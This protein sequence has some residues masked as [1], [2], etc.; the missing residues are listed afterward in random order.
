MATALQNSYMRDI[1][2]TL[3]TWIAENRAFAVATVVGTAGSSPRVIGSTMAV[4]EDGLI[5]GSVS[6]GCVEGAVV[7]AALRAIKTGKGEMLEFGSDSDAV[8]FSVGLS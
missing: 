2:T 8:L 7:Q 4:R 3:S 1:A 5:A 6:G